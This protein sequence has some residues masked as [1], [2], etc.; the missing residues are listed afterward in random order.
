MLGA[1]EIK[2]KKKDNF[3]IYQ[4]SHGGENSE[5]AD[6]ILPGAAFSEKNG[7]YVNLEG[8]VQF[9]NQANFPPGLAKVDWKIIKALS[10]K[11][12]NKISIDS[13]KHLRD[14]LINDFP[15]FKKLNLIPGYNFKNIQI[16]ECM[17]ENQK[18]ISNNF[19]F[20]FSNI[21]ARSSKTMRECMDAKILL[22]KTGT[23]N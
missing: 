3:V 23:D 4:G 7:T 10:E 1:D 19:N 21:I 11:F 22:K 20:Y 2:I 18:I 12:E 9:A 14:N 13:E 16:K 8:R 15:Y 5:I 17:F 6:V